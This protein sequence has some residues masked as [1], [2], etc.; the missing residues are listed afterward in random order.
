MGRF[1]VEKGRIKRNAGQ[2]RWQCAPSLIGKIWERLT[3][4]KKRYI[5]EILN[6]L[7]KVDRALSPVETLKL[8]KHAAECWKINL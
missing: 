3:L 8:S 1:R 7:E 4:E 6:D 2:M 5:R